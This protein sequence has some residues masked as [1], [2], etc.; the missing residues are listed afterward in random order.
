MNVF[1]CSTLWCI[2]CWNCWSQIIYMVINTCL[3]FCLPV[4]L[5]FSIYICLFIYL[6]IHLS[7]Y[8]LSIHLSIYLSKCERER[9]AHTLS[10]PPD[11]LPSQAPSSFPSIL[12][13]PPCHPSPLPL[14]PASKCTCNASIHSAPLVAARPSAQP[15]PALQEPQ[16]PTGA[17]CEPSWRYSAPVQL[18]KPQ[19]SDQRFA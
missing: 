4:Y 8:Y 6:Y 10:N 11:P 19:R 17:R 1:L 14:P 9:E 7:I 16:I 3:S 18:R 13:P 15:F 5:H 2:T 12:D